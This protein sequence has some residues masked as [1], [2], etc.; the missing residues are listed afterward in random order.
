MQRSVVTV[1]GIPS[2]TTSKV[3]LFYAGIS[4]LEKIRSGLYLNLSCLRISLIVIKL[5]DN[6][7][8]CKNLN[9]GVQ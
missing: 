8:D 6:I 3:I 5:N 9:Q 1:I 4:A 7:T 2:M